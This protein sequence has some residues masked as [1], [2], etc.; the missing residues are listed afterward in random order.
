MKVKDLIQLLLKQP[1]EATVVSESD[2]RCLSCE[3]ESLPIYYNVNE[4]F[5]KEEGSYPNSDYK[6]VVVLE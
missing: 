1:Q 4:V 3:D 2:H 6:N 5:F